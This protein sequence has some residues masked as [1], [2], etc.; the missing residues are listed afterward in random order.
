MR[1]TVGGDV[2]PS[3]SPA[4]ARTHAIAQQHTRHRLSVNRRDAPGSEVTWLAAAALD[5][6]RSAPLHCT[7]LHCT[8]LLPCPL[9]LTSS[10]TTRRAE[11]HALAEARAAFVAWTVEAEAATATATATQTAGRGQRA[12]E[13]TAAAEQRQRQLFDAVSCLCELFH[14]LLVLLTES[15]RDA[16]G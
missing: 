11:S 12:S 3:S 13:R 7:P 5:C 6:R 1:A 4:T 16:A 2:F 14:V 15:H 8:A 9:S 10:C